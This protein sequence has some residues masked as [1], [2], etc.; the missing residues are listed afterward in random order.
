L[1]QLWLVAGSLATL[2]AV[3]QRFLPDGVPIFAHRCGP[4]CGG[5]ADLMPLSIAMGVVVAV[6]SLSLLR[7]VAPTWLWIAASCLASSIATSMLMR[8]WVS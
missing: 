6:L 2:L 8:F 4:K 5:G 3:A 7:R 1:R